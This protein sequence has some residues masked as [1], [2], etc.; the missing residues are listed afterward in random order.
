MGCGVGREGIF[1]SPMLPY[2]RLE[3]G[4]SCLLLSW[5]SR[6][7]G[8]FICATANRVNS[9]VLPRWVTRSALPFATASEE[10]PGPPLLLAVGSK[11]EHLSLTYVVTWL[12]RA[13]QGQLCY[14][15]SLRV[16]S[17]ITVSL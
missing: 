9:S 13:E 12:T 6:P 2:G 15:H 16:V 3:G 1:L 17:P 8:Q 4:G 10:I 14:P 5:L 11:G 7:Q